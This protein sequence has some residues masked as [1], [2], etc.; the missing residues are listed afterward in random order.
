ML[1]SH[2]KDWKRYLAS[3]G[4]DGTKDDVCK[5]WTTV[6]VDVIEIFIQAIIHI[7]YP[8]SFKPE[9]NSCARVS[10]IDVPHGLSVCFIPERNS[11]ARMSSIED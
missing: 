2:S 7:N 1:G 6:R 10:S 4:G 3:Y 11:C 8:V 5:T 9:R